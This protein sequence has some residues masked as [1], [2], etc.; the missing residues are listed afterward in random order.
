MASRKLGWAWG[1]ASV[2]GLA[3][4]GCEPPEPISVVAPGVD[5]RQELLKQKTKG[6]EPQAKGELP[7]AG[8]DAP[9]KKV[10]EVPPAEPTPPGESR[11]TEGGVEY[12]TLKEGSGPAVKPG[13]KVKVHYT[14][15]LDDGRKFDSSHDRGE[16]F[17]TQIGVKDVIK[18]WDEAIPG[19]RVGEIRKLVIP[20]NLAYGA[21]GQPPKIP[22]NATLT[23]EIE[24]LS[25]K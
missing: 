6:D 13:Q 7:S 16:A 23:F 18:G 21:Q 2:L 11:K 9:E 1:V 15:K 24:L 5:P 14:G 4:L 3:V 19:M 17:E 12:T 22:P 10:T 8:L 25:V 20:P